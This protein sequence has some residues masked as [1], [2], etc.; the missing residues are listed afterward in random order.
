MHNDGLTISTTQRGMSAG[1]VAWKESRIIRSTIRANAQAQFD[2]FTPTGEQARSI[3]SRP[4]KELTV[5]YDVQSCA[6]AR[7][8]SQKLVRTMRLR[9][10]LQERYEAFS[11]V[12][13]CSLTP[14]DYCSRR[15]VEFPPDM[16]TS[17]PFP[18]L[19]RKFILRT[20]LSLVFVA[21]AIVVLTAWL[22]FLPWV[23]I[24][25]LRGLFAGGTTA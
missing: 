11:M 15:L 14:S 5:A 8:Y 1:Y 24:G 12:M 16:P 19:C 22:A 10:H 18:V 4:A 20:I 13:S 7:S 23:T 2:M 25:I 3:A 9:F 17:L 21:R 6:M